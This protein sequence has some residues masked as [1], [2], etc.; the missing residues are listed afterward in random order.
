MRQEPKEN[1]I[2]LADKAVAAILA[3]RVQGPRAMGYGNSFMNRNPRVL[4]GIKKALVRGLVRWEY[5]AAAVEQVWKDVRD[6][7]VLEEAAN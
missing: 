2:A 1:A 4:R 5:D 6:M 3:A 7:A